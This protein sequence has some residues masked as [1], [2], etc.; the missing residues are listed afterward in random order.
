MG[1][2]FFFDDYPNLSQLGAFGGVDD[3][4]SF[5]AFVFGGFSGPTGRPVSLLTFL[6][7]STSWP[8]EP[9][10]FKIFNVFVHL[11]NGVLVFLVSK[12]L[13]VRY[14]RSEIRFDVSCRSLSLMAL[15]CASI[16]MLHPYLVST[17]LYVIQRMAMLSAL[18]CLL[19]MYVY[20]RGRD[21]FV[22]APRR[23]MILMVSGISIGTVLAAFSKENGA[24]L[25]VLLLVYELTL[26]EREKFQNKAFS[27]FKIVFLVLPLCF[28][29][30][31]LIFIVCNNG[32]FSN[33]STRDFSPYERLITQPRVILSYLES[34]FFPS[35]SGGRLF[36]DDLV[37]SRGWLSPWTTLLSISFL[38]TFVALSLF[39]RKKYPLLVFSFLFFLG[40]QLVESTTVGLE[41]KFDHRVYLGSVFIALPIVVLAQM[42]LS[43]RVKVLAG[44][45]AL[46]L[47][48]GASFSA[49]TLWGDYDSLTLVWAKKQPLSVRAQTEAAQMHFNAGR[50]EASL[51]VL[52]TAAKR[53]PDNLKLRLTQ[54]LVQCQLGIPP[55]S[56]LS[57]VKRAAKQGQYRYT[58]FGLLESFFN[59]ALDKRCSGVTLVDFEEVVAALI[60]AKKGISSRS[61]AYSQL[62]YYYG[63]VLLRLGDINAA[64]KHLGK[65]LK[66][67]A[68]LSMRM[69]IAAEKAAAGLFSEALADANHVRKRLESGKVMGKELAEAPRLDDVL[70]FIDV[71][72][73]DLDDQLTRQRKQ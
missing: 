45:A 25:P 1:G 24:V 60:S 9:Y 33:Y 23:G 40:S 55:E 14:K 47:V 61:L 53:I 59:G 35:F 43:K 3:W 44:C 39:W 63:I 69:K 62:H 48:S 38:V 8:A 37:V 65:S 54:A 2:P 28:I 66:S 34:W 13:L 49:S 46:I 32:L 27:F 29:V 42:Y 72:G 16:W 11:L 15:F 18:F 6:F 64:K 12:A 20:L 21:V 36:Y 51:D 56:A 71:V 67:R 73:K 7:N 31:Y 58:D 57:S 17:T 5:K 52:S 4:A 10:G 70:G 50:Y 22:V 26:G 19:G 41:I 30:F 68:S